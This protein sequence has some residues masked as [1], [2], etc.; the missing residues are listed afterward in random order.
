M[1]ALYEDGL[2]APNDVPAAARAFAASFIADVEAAP[3]LQEQL[4]RGRLTRGGLTRIILRDIDGGL[5]GTRG[6]P[7][8]FPNLRAVTAEFLAQEARPVHGAG[9]GQWDAIA[10][11]VGAAA[12]AAT[13]IYSAKSNIDM[14]QQALA[15]QQKQVKTASSIA[16]LQAKTA[17]AQLAAANVAATG[18]TSSSPIGQFIQAVGGWPAAGAMAAAV[19]LAVGAYFALRRR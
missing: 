8:L 13:S 12:G 17:Q 1:R 15:L 4:V 18:I 19:A 7:A 5:R 3:F 10:S 2:G 9:M 14:Q 11:L 16:D 6:G